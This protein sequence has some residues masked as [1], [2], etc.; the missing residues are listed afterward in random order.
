[1]KGPAWEEWLLQLPS[2]L[3][4]LA[5]AILTA[6]YD[7]AR[8]ELQREKPMHPDLPGIVLRVM[9]LRSGE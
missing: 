9:R 3:S 2:P 1:M 5:R 4:H 6:W 7:R 8:A